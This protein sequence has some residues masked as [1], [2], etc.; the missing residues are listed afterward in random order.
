MVDPNDL[1]ILIS[2][3][4]F[5]TYVAL[6]GGDRLLAHDLYEWTGD[7]AGALI[8]DFRTLEVVFR[9]LVDQALTNHVAATAPH[10]TDWLFDPSW[11]P[12]GSHWWNGAGQRILNQAR[13]RAGGRNATHGA[14]VAE[15]MFGFWRYVVAGRYEESF[16]IPALDA[17]FSGI[18]GTAPGDRRR[19]LEQSMINLNGLRNRIAHHEPI[20]KPWTRGLPGGSIG[21]FTVD[22]VYGDVVQVLEW[23][24]PSHAASLLASSRVP[25]LL[26]L[27]PC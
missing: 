15:L 22:D 9:N 4:R 18:P 11:L 26:A 6:A 5:A 23:A 8:T 2:Q 7:L 24:T 25:G 14:I 19:A 20:A 21:T 16:W 12:T 1:E 3:P 27:R 10:V 17:A 13:N